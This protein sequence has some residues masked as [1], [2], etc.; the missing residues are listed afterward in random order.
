MPSFEAAL[1][2]CLIDD[3]RIHEAIGQPR[4]VCHQLLNCHG[5]RLGFDVRHIAPGPDGR[6]LERW[7]VSAH[8]M[9]QLKA[10]R[11]IKH[12]RRHR[13]DRLGHRINTNDGVQRKSR[14]AFDIGP[15]HRLFK[16]DTASATNL[17]TG[18]SEA[19]L[20]DLLS[21]PG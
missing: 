16:G 10:A 9:I 8:W 15:S 21:Q 6:V 4:R 7:N 5:R 11:F 18:T 20:V 2:V 14:F 13:G 19:F 17:N 1:T 3:V 12:H